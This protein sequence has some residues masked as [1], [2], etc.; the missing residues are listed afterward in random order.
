[1]TCAVYHNSQDWTSKS[2]ANF[3]QANQ[4]RPTHSTRADFNEDVQGAR[5]IAYRAEF[6]R[7][8]FLQREIIGELHDRD[9]VLR[10]KIQ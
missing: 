2:L 10:G 4:V 7:R 5:V 8:Q 6:S 3:Q 9:A 1:M